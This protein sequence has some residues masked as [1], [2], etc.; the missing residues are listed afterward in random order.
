M[1]RGSAP[2]GK[3]V[4][5]AHATEL[6]GKVKMK[7]TLFERGGGRLFLIAMGLWGLALLGGC[8]APAFLFSGA[9]LPYN[10]YEVDAGKVYRC[11]QP[12]GPELGNAIDLLGIKTVLN[13]RGA[14][15]GD[16][17]YDQEAE[18]CRSK[19]VVLVDYAMSSGSLPTPELLAGIVHTL[20]TAAYPLLIHCAGG[21]DR[22]G[23]VS[24]IYR[25][26]IA[27]D[28]KDQAL[29][30]LSLRYFHFEWSAPCMDVLGE[31]YEPTDEW[32]AAYAETYGQVTCGR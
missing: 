20:D 30:Q 31:M 25:M 28:E 8:S 26:R 23:L 3:E 10:F 13:L 9:D 11:A 7:H 5:G 18:V 1:T 17:W 16:E 12:T 14:H 2:P 27:G 6:T 19:G 24:A 29:E 15:P 32:L 21:A 22:T 4:G